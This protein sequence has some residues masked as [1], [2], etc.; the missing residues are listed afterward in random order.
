MRV[1]WPT[2]LVSLTLIAERQAVVADLVDR[3]VRSGAD[4]GP[5]DWGVDADRILRAIA[6]GA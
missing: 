3:G 5:A 6:K 4:E 1:D 2:A